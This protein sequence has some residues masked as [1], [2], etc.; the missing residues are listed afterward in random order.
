ML[1]R[2]LGEPLLASRAG[3]R[4]RL[5]DAVRVLQPR[6]RP[7]DFNEALMELGA[8]V[9]MPRNPR[10]ADCPVARTCRAR[11]GGRISELPPTL[12]RSKPITV[13]AAAALIVD[14]GLV[15][16]QREE[17]LGIWRLLSDCGSA[18]GPLIISSVIIVAPLATAAV[19][20]SLLGVLCTWLVYR[21]VDETLV[22]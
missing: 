17:F 7:G 8:M 4:R 3:D 14:R 11:A 12:P 2:W 5:E 13:H 10:C 22:R 15:L 18:A 6:D 16:G 20:I 21:H 9:C 1:S 19:S